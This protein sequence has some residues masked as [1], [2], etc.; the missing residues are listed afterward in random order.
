MIRL[1]EFT[2][3]ELGK[4]NTKKGKMTKK[5]GNEYM[6]GEKGKRANADLPI[7]GMV[8]FFSS[9]GDELPPAFPLDTKDPVMTILLQNLSL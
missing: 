5:G 7:V 2:G 6:E 4:F 9:V 8:F 1:M 3:V